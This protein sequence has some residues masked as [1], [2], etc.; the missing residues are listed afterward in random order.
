MDRGSFGGCGLGEEEEGVIGKGRLGK[1]D[2]ISF[3]VRGG[4][5]LFRIVALAVNRCSRLL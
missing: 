3:E 5:D 2:E 1:P 4:E